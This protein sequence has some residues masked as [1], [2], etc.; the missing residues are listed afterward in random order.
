MDYSQH[1]QLYD[2]FASVI[3]LIGLFVII[4][5]FDK[6]LIFCE[7]S[8]TF[9]AN[10]VQDFYSYVIMKVNGGYGYGKKQGNFE[11][12]RSGRRRR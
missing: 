2:F 12:T 6:L 5:N 3:M 7:F 10:S 4:L 11:R 9:L 8:I 1:I